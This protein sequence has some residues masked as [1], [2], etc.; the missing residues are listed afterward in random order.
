V[1]TPRWSPDGFRIA[2]RAGDDM[3][4]AVGDNTGGWL[5]ARD[6]A[7]TAPAWQPD[8]PDGDQVLA[9]AAGPRIRIVAVDGRRV[10][11]VTRPG[12]PPRELWWSGR[13]LIAV[14]KD[15]ARVY[16]RRGRLLRTLALP[17][18]L[19]AEGSALDPGGR[20]L[21]IAAPRAGG[22]ASELLLYRL[23]GSAR[24]ERIF[25][26]PGL[27]EGLTWSIDGRLVALGLPGADQWVF[28]R[29]TGELVEV[30]P[31]I[32]SEFGGWARPGGWCYPEPVDRD[33]V[34]Q[35]PCTPGSA[36]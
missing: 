21:A 14:G 25:V 28:L 22:G 19:R 20:R 16:D 13:R 5:L 1:S 7:A 31:N 2:Y 10:L 9:F 6:V 17:A 35:P 3:Y 33:P 12:A 30:V 32:A 36:P 23:K 18:R 27:V 26:G 15:G 29:P 24:P 4:V 8:R 34:G 11:G